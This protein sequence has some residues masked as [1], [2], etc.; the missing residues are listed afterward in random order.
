MVDGKDLNNHTD[1]SYEMIY[2]IIV[3]GDNSIGKTTLIE[4]FVQSEF[5]SSIKKLIGVCRTKQ[6]D[7]VLHEQVFKI[8][9]VV[10][11]LPDSP[12]FSSSLSMYF[13]GVQGVL[14]GLDLTRDQTCFS[15]KEWIA[16]THR[17]GQSKPPIILFG[18]KSDL[19]EERKVFQEHIDYMKEQLEIADFIE[20]SALTGSNVD[21]LFD[22]IAKRV[23]EKIV[24]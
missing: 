5:S 11:D 13:N 7:L 12:Q 14:L 9:L 22:L 17:S 16:K 4:N 3:L 23:S 8:K 10:W 19:I 2:K 15:L 24:L 20:T 21:V 18:N 6:I 1:D